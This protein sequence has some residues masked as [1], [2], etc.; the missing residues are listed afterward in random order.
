MPHKPEPTPS[1]AVQRLH[2]G[3]RALVRTQFFE[4]LLEDQKLKLHEA[5]GVTRAQW[6]QMCDRIFDVVFDR[7]DFFQQITPEQAKTLTTAIL[8]DMRDVGMAGKLAVKEYT[9]IAQ[10]AADVTIGVRAPNGQRAKL[11]RAQQQD[12]NG[13]WRNPNGEIVPHYNPGDG[14]VFTEWMEDATVTNHAKKVLRERSEPMLQAMDDELHED[15]WKENESLQKLTQYA[16]TR[17]GYLRQTVLYIV[18]LDLMGKYPELPTVPLRTPHPNDLEPSSILEDIKER[19]LYNLALL[20]V[21][22][23]NY[24]VAL[25]SAYAYEMKA[26]TDP[27]ALD[28]KKIIALEARAEQ[29]VK[30]SLELYSTIAQENLPVDELDKFSV[31]VNEIRHA[32]SRGLEVYLDSCKETRREGGPGL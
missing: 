7:N 32:V 12:K 20:N 30:K 19:G 4:R 11:H 2:E 15:F 29:Q 27:S 3:R 26:C 14:G 31:G 5:E 9:L 23:D 28:H 25:K 13:N 1:N 18:R 10:H 21:L 24:Q 16:Q 22:Y 17:D 6:H 8:R